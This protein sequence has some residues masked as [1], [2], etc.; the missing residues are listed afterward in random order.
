NLQGGSP[1]GYSAQQPWHNSALKEDGSLRADYMNRL[2][3]VLDQA[4]ELGMVVILGLFYFGQVSGSPMRRQ[5]SAVWTT[6]STGF[7]ITAIATSSSRS[8]MSATSVT[9]TT[10]SNRSAFTS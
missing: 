3:G 1:Q 4:D 5:S 6:P 9:T 8:T 10:S 2:Q 7:S